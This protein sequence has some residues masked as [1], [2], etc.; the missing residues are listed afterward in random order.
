MA[1][2][3][4]AVNIN[5][6]ITYCTVA[7]EMRGKGRCNHIAHQNPGESTSDFMERIENLNVEKI[8]RESVEEI[9][10]KPF[11]P[12]EGTT[13]TT[14]PYRMSEEEKADLTHIQNRMQLDQNI[15]GGYIELEEPLWN[16]MDKSYF[17]EKS[18]MSKK[19]INSVLHE[20]SAVILSSNDPKFPV[21][22]AIPLYI[23]ER[24][25]V[26]GREVVKQIPID[27]SDKDISFETGPKGMN[28]YAK[29]EYDW[30]ATRDL[31]VLPYYMR[32]GSADIDSDL[33]VGYKYL[34]RQH[35][36]PAAQQLAY[37]SL[38]NNSNMATANARYQ[39]GYRNKSLAD[40]FAGKGGVFRACLSGNSIP[41]SGRTVITPSADMAYGELKI[42]P[43]VAVDIYRP[44][45]LKQ[46]AKEGKSIKEIDDYFEQFR[47]DQ[48]EVSPEARADLERRISG[49]R[50]I[51]NRQPSLHT[52]SLQ[53]YKPRISENA[54]TQIHPLYCKAYGADF[55]GDCVTLYA[56]NDT[57]MVP[58]VDRSI[59][60]TLDVNTHQPRA[61]NNSAIPIEKDSLWGLMNILER[62][63]N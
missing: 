9:Y 23:E 31:Y 14:K 26:R 1:K 33:T 19:N 20:E 37:E 18:G 63:S 57:D 44:T 59:G 15:D 55:D 56:I 21:G 53:S 25:I 2:K 22:K 4:L 24:E 52:S 34:L 29:Q 5:G 48:T 47:G 46:F 30:E 6:D 62:R 60:A 61:I 43:S 12:S 7:P 17:S 42:P 28:Q 3:V 36:N 49:K 27:Y 58:V 45:L 51:M 16:D 13:I 11:I 10:E 41:Y 54:T 40:E 50:V 8:A 38:L 39:R 32:M 35:N